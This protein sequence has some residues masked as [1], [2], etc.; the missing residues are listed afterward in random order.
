[1]DFYRRPTK[2]MSPFQIR[3]VCSVG[4]PSPSF[5]VFRLLPSRS[6]R[7]RKEVPPGDKFRHET[8]ADL[9]EMKF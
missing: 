1:M 3:C 2:H 5:H 4:I 8:Y 7:V 6:F 9:L